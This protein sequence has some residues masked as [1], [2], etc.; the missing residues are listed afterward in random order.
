MCAVRAECVQSCAE[1]CEQGQAVW[2]A[3]ARLE[4]VGVDV[5]GCDAVGSTA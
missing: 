1:Q 2:V 4:C 3:G 5:K